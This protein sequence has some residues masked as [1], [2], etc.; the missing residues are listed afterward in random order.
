MVFRSH[1]I[2]ACCILSGRLQRFIPQKLAHFEEHILTLHTGCTK[3]KHMGVRAGLELRV[4]CNDKVLNDMKGSLSWV[5]SDK[6]VAHR[7][8]CN[9]LSLVAL[10]VFG[11]INNVNTADIRR[12]LS[13]WVDC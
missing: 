12:G 11:D 10:G 7:S 9:A 4:S 5:F 3:S 8:L 2:G 13:M 6:D 1:P